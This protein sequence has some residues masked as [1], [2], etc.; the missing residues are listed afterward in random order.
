MNLARKLALSGLLCGITAVSFAQNADEIIKKH[1]EAVG[2]AKNWDNIKSVKITG[3]ASKRGQEVGMTQTIVNN[4]GWRLDIS[5]AGQKGYMIATPTEGW[6]FMPFAGHTAPQPLPAEQL[7]MMQDKLNFK[8]DQLADPSA[9]A[10]ATV[11]GKDVIEKASCYKLKITSRDGNEFTCYIDE[12]NY[13]LKRIER[14]IKM[15]DGDQELAITYADFQKQSGGIVYPM[16]A[17]S[18]QEEIKYKSV[19]INKVTDEK[20]FKPECK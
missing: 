9:I 7:K 6:I 20:I 12:Q 14:T 10:M 15:P 4:K 5:A 16:S 2:G 8:N 17:T 18:N 13:Y 3:S 11:D 1:I 19:E